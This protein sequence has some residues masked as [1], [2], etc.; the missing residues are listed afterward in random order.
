MIG[1]VKVESINFF[2]GS[3]LQTEYTQYVHSLFW[4]TEPIHGLSVATSFADL[5]FTPHILHIF[6][7]SALLKRFGFFTGLA[8]ANSTN[9]GTGVAD[10]KLLAGCLADPENLENPE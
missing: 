10:M 7:S 4:P 6:S 5:N 3:S 1:T 8:W 9:D 2:L